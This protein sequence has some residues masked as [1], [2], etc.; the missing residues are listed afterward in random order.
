M[1]AA[2][3]T[4]SDALRP[5]LKWAGGKRWQVPQ[6]RLLWEPHA[7]R[8]LVEPFAGGLAVALG[9]R[10]ERALLNDA[11][12]H[13]INFYRWL[14]TGLRNSIP[15]ENNEV[16]FYQHRDR[17]NALMRAG[18]SNSQESAELFYFLNRTGY[19]G[20]CRFN[21]HGEFNVPFG[22][23]HSIT[24]A[25]AFPAFREA[26]ADWDFTVGDFADMPLES[27][28]F[29][30]ADPP[31][32]VEF[33]SYSQGGFSWDDQTRTA[34]VLARHG[35]PA[36]LVNQFTPRIDALYRS[37]GYEVRYLAGPRRISCNGDR[38]PAKEILGTRNL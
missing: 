37:L 25:K 38:T 30:Y 14:K 10:P 31:Y 33:T 36:V 26:F 27:D 19:N 29:V 21:S 3:T 13:L 23:Y 32:D 22:R 8:R 9:L 2:A 35:G 7:Q 6:L 4:P 24:Y 18:R 15:M 1:P 16:L 28:D 34:E 11:N 12:P 20:L 5:P 17:F